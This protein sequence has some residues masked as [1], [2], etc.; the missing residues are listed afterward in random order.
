MTLVNELFSQAAGLEAMRNA[1]G[2]PPMSEY[3]E[4]VKTYYHLSGDE[5]H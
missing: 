3:I 4:M 5:K 2:L 1:L